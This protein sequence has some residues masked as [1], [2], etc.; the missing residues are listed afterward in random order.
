MP[1]KARC[2]ARRR[3][4]A[5]ESRLLA[6][7][8]ELATLVFGLTA[9]QVDAQGCPTKGLIESVGQGMPGVQGVPLLS[10]VSAALQGVGAR[11]PLLQAEGAWARP[12]PS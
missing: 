5:L 3:A 4:F 9:S 11:I 10:T 2:L 8:L 7:T 6:R 12:V 1:Q